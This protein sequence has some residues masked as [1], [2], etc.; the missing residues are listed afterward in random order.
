MRVSSRS[1]KILHL[2]MDHN[3]VSD[4]RKIFERYYPG[5]NVF[6]VNSRTPDLKMIRD[7][8]GFI[9][10]DMY[11]RKNYAEVLRL[12]R[13][14]G[15]DRI[16]LHGMRDYMLFLLRYLRKE[17][18]FR[19]FWIVWGYEL[20][21][22]LGYERGYRL[23][24]R[25]FP[26]LSKLRYYAPGRMSRII[27]K[28]TNNYRPGRFARIF[29]MVDYFCFWNRRDY[30]LLKDNFDVKAEFRFFS[31]NANDTGSEPADLFELRDR[32]LETVMINHQASV[33]GNHEKV[34]ERLMEVDPDNTLRKLVPLSYGHPMIR[35][36]VLKS[37]QRKFGGKF[38][39]VTDYMSRDDYFK[40][41]DRVDVAIFGQRRQEA[42]GNIIQLLKNGVKV[43][44]R[45]DN[46]LLDYYREKGYLIYS[47]DDDLK[48]MGSLEPLTMEE[49]LHN[50]ECFMRNRLYYDIFMPHLLD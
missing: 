30:D 26:L 22:T 50:R 39:P 49:Q 36:N 6:V 35:R 24:D 9:C 31:Y 32:R 10:L 23:F 42:S 38:C 34:F 45:N 15:V 17:C 40:V 5:M 27:R 8:E 47:F 37:G 4:S 13:E 33:F 3:F 2:C 43:F 21:E 14:N 46:N 28:V 12:C 44:L 25:P 29:G 20:Y 48:D 1:G 16:V 19:V 18:D 11:D 41:L 7:K